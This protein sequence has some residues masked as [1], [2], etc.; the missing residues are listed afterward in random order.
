[1]AITITQQPAQD[2]LANR[3]LMFAAT[4]N[5][6][7][8]TGFRF[9]VVVTT[10]QGTNSFWIPPNPSGAAIIDIAQLVKLNNQEINSSASIHKIIAPLL[11]PSGNGVIYDYSV[12]IQEAWEVAGVLTLQGSATVSTYDMMFNGNLQASDPNTTSISTRYTLDSSTKR[13]ASDRKPTTHYWLY[14]NLYGLAPDSSTIYIPVREADWGV[15]TI[16]WTR[17]KVANALKVTIYEADGTN[18]AASL[19]VGGINAGDM[20]H[21][22][23]Y[24]A[25]LN[26]NTSGLP[27]PSDYPDWR[28][29]TIQALENNA[30]RSMKYVLY[31]TA[32]LLQKECIYN[33]IRIAWKGF[34]GSWEYFN[35]IKK[36]EKSYNIDRKQYRKVLGTYGSTYTMIGQERGLTEVDVVAEQ[37]ITANSDW[38]SEGEFEFLTGLFVSRQVMIVNDDGTHT[39]VVVQDSGFTERKTRDGKQVN[40]QIQ[41]KYSNNLWV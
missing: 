12:S 26:V 33:N 5:N 38:L 11:E 23:F 25:N 35:F 40:Q 21:Y 20:Y 19:N 31:N 39:P 6:S 16:P 30:A 7:A 9:R 1:M 18:T 13:F 29:I 27:K 34:G 41:L 10:T 15:M 8:N 14:G 17:T 22:P 4:S 3:R 28:Y 36:N 24:P 37:V 32:N 2:A